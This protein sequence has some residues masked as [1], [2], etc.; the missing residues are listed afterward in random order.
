MPLMHHVK[1]GN[2]AGNEMF[3]KFFKGA[4]LCLYLVECN[5]ETMCAAPHHDL[6]KDISCF[7]LTGCKLLEELAV[8]EMFTKIFK[9]A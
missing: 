9:G 2:L 8:N 3:T 7:S 6:T 5:L 4:L 1:T